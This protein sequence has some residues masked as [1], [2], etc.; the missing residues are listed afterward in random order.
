VIDRKQLQKDCPMPLNPSPSLGCT[1]CRQPLSSHP[2]MDQTHHFCCSGC[3]AVFSILTT[4]GESEQFHNHPLFLQAVR[5]GLISNP[6][7]LEQIRDRTT[8]FSEGECQRLYFEVGEMWCPSCAEVIRLVLLQE[9]GIKNC[10]IDYATDMASVQFSPKLIAKE[11]IFQKIVDLGYRP[12]NLEEREQKEVSKNLYLRFA[13]AAFCAFNAMMFAYP[14]YAIHFENDVG[15]EGKVFAWISFM[16]SLPVITYA[17][18]P[19]LHRFWSSFS[20]GLLGM[21]A[22][23]ILGVGAAF[24]ASTFELFSG[25][26]HVYFDSMSVIIAFVLLGKIIE[27]KAK[28]SA[29]ESLFRLNLALPKRGRKNHEDGSYSFVSVKS[30]KIGDVIEVRMGEMIVLDGVVKEGEGICNESLMTGEP[31]PV[32]KKV[33]S[34]VAGGTL[35]QHGIL[36]VTITTESEGST[37]QHIV[38]IIEQQMS[39]KLAYFRPADAIVHWFVP[40]VL[41]IA[42]L[43]MLVCLVFGVTDGDR[44]VQET[45]FLRAISVLLISCPCAIGIAAPTAEAALIRSLAAHGA[46]VRNRGCLRYLGAETTFIF[47]KTGTIT[48]GKFTVLDGLD[49]L[50]DQE[51]SLLKGM[52]ERSNH[53]IANGINMSLSVAPVKLSG[54]EEF[55]GKGIRA[56]LSPEVLTYY[57][58]GRSASVASHGGQ[59]TNGT[60]LEALKGGVK[61]TSKTVAKEIVYLLGS[62]QFLTEQGVIVPESDLNDGLGASTVVYFGRIGQEAIPLVLGDQ[63]RED[64]KEVVNTISKGETKTALVS[65]DSRTS[66]SAIAQLCQFDQWLAHASPLEKQL[67]VKKLKNSGEIV[68]MVG[69]GINDS[70]ALTS[71]HVG[72]SVATATDVSIQVS[73]LLLTSDRLTVIPHIRALA[74]KGRRIVWQNLFWAFFY[75]VIGIALAACGWLSPIFAAFAMTASSLIVLFNAM[76]L[77]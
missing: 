20:V 67:Y 60:I 30:L 36:Q 47:D 15:I 48:R 18:W 58:P 27:S 26:T 24:V 69:D 68:G 6:A 57:S 39:S 37:L 31:I 14:L 3:Q 56:V 50:S 21:E 76:R 49:R 2:I 44:S 7:L 72:I 70:P 19:I 51:K 59:G 33:G 74:S 43:T 65:G 4:R 38:N 10:S 75:N 9:K 13:I 53:P 11:R 55:A 45:A 5:S 42:L 8:Q 61:I 35:L 28:F 1:L 29:K 62:S 25:G 34:A 77:R 22:L 12:Y 32:A 40:I 41:V 54:V 23:V 63:L 73:D 17:G 16:I 66:V 52:V 64:A 46:I 71:A